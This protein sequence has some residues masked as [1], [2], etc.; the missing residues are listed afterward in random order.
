MTT[1]VSK[2]IDTCL[3]GPQSSGAVG[4]GPCDAG[5]QPS[6][7][8]GQIGTLR[9]KVLVWDHDPMSARPHQVFSW[10]FSAS[11][12]TQMP[13]EVPTAFFELGAV[14]L[15]PNFKRHDM[16]VGTLP[17]GFN[18]EE[19]RLSVEAGES[20]LTESSL[21][22]SPESGVG[23]IAQDKMP[24]GRIYLCNGG[25]GATDEED[26]PCDSGSDPDTGRD[27]W[28][29]QVWIH[30]GSLFSF[31]ILIH[32]HEYQLP[33]SQLVSSGRA[34]LEELQSA[35]KWDYIEQTI[36]GTSS[37]WPLMTTKHS[38]DLGNSVHWRLWKWEGVW[39]GQD[40]F[41]SVKLGDKETDDAQD[42]NDDSIMKLVPELQPYLSYNILKD[43]K[44]IPGIS[45]EAFHIP[46]ILATLG[47]DKT[48]KE[49]DEETARLARQ[50]FDWRY[51][52]YILIEIGHNSNDN[53]YFIELVKGRHPR[54]L[55]L[56]EEWDNP[57]RL[58]EGLRA[59]DASE[60]EG[61]PFEF[62]KKCRVL[63]VYENLVCD[64]LF[65][66]DFALSVRNHLGRMV[67]TFQGYEGDPWVITRKDNDQTKRD[68]SKII[69]P[70]VVPASSRQIIYG[71]NISCAINYSPTQYFPSAILPF[72]DRQVDTGPDNGGEVVDKDIFIS[73]SNVGNTQ[74]YG[75]DS[76]TVKENFFND[77]RMDL[78][79]IGY[80]CDA[81]LTH[82][83][84]GNEL[85]TI[86][87]YESYV[88]QYKKYYKAWNTI[89]RLDEDGKVVIDPETG[90]SIKDFV[91][92][93]S[94]AAGGK[95]SSLKILNLRDVTKKFELKLTDKEFEHYQWK[96]FIAKWDI[97][98]ELNAG[99][100]N[101]TPRTS[102]L[103]KDNFEPKVFENYI[104]P[105]ATSWR[106]VVLGGGKSFG[107]K[108]KPI[109]IEPLVSKINDSWSAED[110]TSLSHEMQMECY[111]PIES[112]SAANP[113]TKEGDERFPD[114]ANLFNI[115]RSLISL[116]DKTFYVT[117]SYW[118]DKGI[119]H[120]Y[121]KSN[122]A[123]AF[124]TNEA[125]EDVLIEPEENDVLIQMTG[126]A[127][128]A[129]LTKSNNRMI[130][131]FTIKDYM[132]ILEN[133]FIFNSPFFD[134]V[135]DVHAVHELAKMAGFEDLQR[136]PDDDIEEAAIFAP[137]HPIISRLPLGYLR[138]VIINRTNTGIPIKDSKFVY[139]GE[140]SR[141]ERYD[142]PGTYSTF[143][144]P[145]V[146]FQNGETYENAVKRIAQLGGKTI[147]FDRWGVL[148]LETPAALIAAFFKATSDKD[149][150]DSLDEAIK[151]VF[152]FVST[153]K[154]R[155]SSITVTGKRG[156]FL[157]DPSVHA[158]HLVYNATN[159]QRSVE[160]CSN[161][162]IIMSAS[163]DLRDEKGERTGGFIIEGYTFF[164]QMWHPDAEGFIGYRKPMYQEEG[165]FGSIEGVRNAIRIYAKKKFPPVIMS[166]ETFGV[167]GLK[168]LEKSCY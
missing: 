145:A 108:I 128:G 59:S 39:Q 65:K 74:K 150:L 61:Q 46:R 21:V 167:P 16:F 67:V 72:Y 48:Q 115:G 111:I 24:G 156:K 64:D 144:D 103:V 27:I 155:N 127:Y 118:W 31:E 94:E 88:N 153:P 117:V 138:H 45:N 43:G 113:K 52:T 142:L 160:E 29:H 33:F 166:F 148:K 151:P 154:I 159:Y 6:G 158:A 75:G 120:K 60:T 140:T 106:I 143:I 100:V 96:D 101:M 161:Q 83:I 132:S 23:Q 112:I 53:H 22:G 135:Q 77:P 157:F 78:Q 32:P 152:D 82:E 14:L 95:P 30:G 105:I 84:I 35:A 68:F 81:Y 133:Q 104:T 1:Q 20:N 79:S 110:F 163:N 69:V 121:V 147:Y 3:C 71:G 162:I 134:A 42:P 11:T 131:S 70:M 98:I 2:P 164:D 40:F 44:Q 34:S 97:G 12:N 15:T 130:M 26:N 55:H 8:P 4:G 86:R 139:N 73:F 76:K 92:S 17:S 129:K 49:I 93:M 28:P 124:E 125:G 63:S 149:I 13:N 66:Q 37:I 18:V 141:S 87:V 119:G 51:K 85:K 91:N 136:L 10:P 122:E 47:G 137:A 116:H 41:I 56:G 102:K 5:P 19:A 89:T 109:N 36:N 9:S 123:N 25:E 107:G 57:K 38:P 126:L 90:L 54:F 62:V 99:S 58:E 168:A 7:I 165:A 80:D 146:K 50:A 114:L